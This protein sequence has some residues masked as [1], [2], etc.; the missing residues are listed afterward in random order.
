[1]EQLVGNPLFHWTHLELTAVLRH[2]SGAQP[3]ERAGNLPDR[4]RKVRQ[5]P[6]LSVFGI[7]KKF[8]VYA[9][10]TTVDPADD[11]HYHQ[12]IASEGKCPAKVIPSFRPYKALN[13]DKSISPTTSPSSARPPASGSNR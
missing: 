13:I 7:M 10:G 2:R 5:R 3:Q 12:V 4:Q 11:L 9:V 8:N 1:M 6:E